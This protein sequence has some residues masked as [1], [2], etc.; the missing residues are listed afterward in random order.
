MKPPSEAAAWMS[1]HPAI[2][3]SPPRPPRPEPPPPSAILSSRPGILGAD[4]GGVP[5]PGLTKSEHHHRD[6]RAWAHCEGFGASLPSKRP[7]SRGRRAGYTPVWSL[8]S[9]SEVEAL[10]V[11]VPTFPRAA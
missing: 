11:L 5:A 2:L 8:G 6:S 3:A 1:A 10:E 7:A 9:E 4:T